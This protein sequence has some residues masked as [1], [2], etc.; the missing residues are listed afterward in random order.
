[1][2]LRDFER[3]LEINPENKDAAT[4]IDKVKSTKKKN[5]E[6]Q[7]AM[8]AKMFRINPKHKANLA[9][10]THLAEVSLKS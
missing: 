1:L 2:A 3:A 5:R 9:K 6:K 10:K 8:Y 7:N 4:K